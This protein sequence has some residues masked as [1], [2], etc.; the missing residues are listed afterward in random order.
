MIL[1]QTAQRLFFFKIYTY[2]FGINHEDAPIQLFTPFKTQIEKHICIN[3]WGFIFLNKCPV[4][5]SV[6]IWFRCRH[7]K[8]IK[9]SHFVISD[10]TVRK[11]LH[12]WK[13]CIYFM[14]YWFL[15]PKVHQNS[16]NDDQHWKQFD[17][18]SVSL[19]L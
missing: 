16:I 19:V 18:R 14:I 9:S 4:T 12:L 17:L 13:I 5:F 2:I 10:T 6:F 3:I 7:S 15:P 8:N 1:L 11:R